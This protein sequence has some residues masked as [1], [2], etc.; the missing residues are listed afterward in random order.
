M[1]DSHSVSGMGF[2]CGEHLTNKVTIA[3]NFREM[4][5]GHFI[6]DTSLYYTA[7]T[8]LVSFRR[9]AVFTNLHVI[10]KPEILT[11]V[12][13]GFV[14]GSCQLQMPVILDWGCLQIKDLYTCLFGKASMS[15][16][17]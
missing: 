1:C 8:G 14:S 6:L 17:H 10:R 12:P 13:D 3:V 2:G 16:S 5:L 4:L 9:F 11:D 15:E 7:A